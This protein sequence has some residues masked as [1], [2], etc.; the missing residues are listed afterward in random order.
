MAWQYRRGNFMDVSLFF[1][2]NSFSCA[3]KNRIDH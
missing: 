1:G 2:I 3:K